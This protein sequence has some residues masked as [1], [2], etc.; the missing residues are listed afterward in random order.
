M[1]NPAAGNALVI[2]QSNFVELQ[3]DYV[4][5]REDMASALLVGQ[6]E[7]IT[8][9]LSNLTERYN[10][11]RNLISFRGGHYEMLFS[12]PITG[13]SATGLDAETTYTGTIDVQG[14]PVEYSVNGANAQ[15]YNQLRGEFNNALYAFGLVIDFDSVDDKLYLQCSYNGEGADIEVNPA[16]AMWGA[17]TN[18]VGFG[19]YVPGKNGVTISRL[20]SANWV[21]QNDPLEAQGDIIKDEFVTYRALAQE[22]L[23]WIESQVE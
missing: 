9:A 11:I 8:D 13:R 21:G 22:V 6:P 1:S 10:A 14:T 15:T 12:E 19:S 5:A 2:S 17:L 18:F 20:T 16:D 4:G 23:D 7:I 3:R